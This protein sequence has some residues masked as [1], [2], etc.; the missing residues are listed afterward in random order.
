MV[1]S[2]TEI[3]PRLTSWTAP[4]PQ[5]RP[6][7]E[8]P[9]DVGCVLY[10]APGTT[11]LI[12]PLI[13]ADLDASAWTWLDDAVAAASAPVAVLLTA[14]WH[15]RSTRAV[16]ERYGAKVWTAP[17]GRAR[18]ADLPPLET[19]PPRVVA[20][21]PRGIDEGQV[22]L[23]LEEERTVVIAELFLGTLSGLQLCPSPATQDLDHFVESMYKLALLP[24]DRVLVSHGVPVM[25]GGNE[26][27]MAAMQSF[28]G[29]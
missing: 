18:I 4:H 10:R 21:A 9:E 25:S 17:R 3:S 28:R 6:N 11:V 13:R 27:M 7:P 29:A 19:L 5:W 15:E 20:F 23:V 26:A 12:D 14:P 2:R 8:W 16:V 1:A 22:A 24:A